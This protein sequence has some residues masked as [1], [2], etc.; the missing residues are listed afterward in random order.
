MIPISGSSNV[1]KIGYDPD[2]KTLRVEFVS[3]TYE[4]AGVPSAVFENLK[5]SPSKGRFVNTEIRGKYGSR[6]VS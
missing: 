6:K 4:Y 3:G 1:E 2:S 5:A